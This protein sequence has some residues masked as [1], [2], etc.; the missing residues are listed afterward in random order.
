MARKNI[1]DTIGAIQNWEMEIAKI[2]KFFKD[3]REVTINGPLSIF[4]DREEYFSIEQFVDKYFF[5][6]WKQR[7]TCLNC[8]EMREKLS[9]QTILA[10]T[11]ISQNEFITYLEH[12]S[13][14]LFISEKV[15]F[16]DK[17]EIIFLNNVLIKKNIE[18]LLGWINHETK[19]FE[20]DEKVL[21]VEKD[22]AVTAVAEIIG[23]NLSYEVIKYNHYTLKG[24]LAAKKSLLI[25]FCNVL[26]RKRT[27]LKESNAQLEDGIFFLANNMNI[28]HNNTTQEENN[29]S[30]IEHVAKMPKEE[31]ENWYDELYQMMLL[32]FLQLDNIDRMK[33]VTNLKALCKQKAQ[34]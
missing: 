26:E 25:K 29:K 17:Y 3:S 5:K 21:I 30:Y 19:V 16:E 20:N 9:I 8:N 4:R 32:A 12:I 7:G 27:K 10:K 24:D 23:E 15:K 11:K 6:H 22:A 18:I 28:R 13:N 34:I 31:L 33:K 2:E 1:F 14:I